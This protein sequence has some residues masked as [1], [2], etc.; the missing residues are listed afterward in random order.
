[1]GRRGRSYPRVVINS[2]KNQVVAAVG[3]TGTKQK[4]I[5]A[6]AVNTPLSTVANDV[7]NGCKIQAIWLSI[8]GCG[9]GGT[10]VLNNM[11]FYFMKNPGDNLTEPTPTS[12]GTSNE[13]KYIFKAWSFMVMRNQDGNNP[14][15]WE[16]WVKIPRLYQRMGT[17]DTIIIEVNN[18]SALTGN[19]KVEAIYKWYK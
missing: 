19:F 14:F 18:T 17:D 15:H 8:D 2:I 6:K 5:I 10:G 1:M 13:K 4:I 16:G 12:W 9:L 7:G 11:F 3:T